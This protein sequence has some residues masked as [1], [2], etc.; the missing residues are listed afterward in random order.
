MPPKEK[1]LQINDG[2]LMAI[3][4]EPARVDTSQPAIIFLNAG[5]VHKIGPFRMN[6]QIARHLS[7]QLG[8][9]SIRFD[10][11]NIGD[12]AIHRGKIQYEY[13]VLNNISDTMNHLERI[14]G[15]T[16]FIIMGLCTGADNAHKI[17]AADERVCG[18]VFWDGYRYPTPKY[19][20]RRYWQYFL[21]LPR[22]SIAFTSTPKKISPKRKE[23]NNDPELSF[24]WV[25]PTKKNVENDFKNFLARDAKMLFIFSGDATKD[26]NYKG[27]L[28]NAFRRLKLHANIEEIYY[29]EMDH[30]YMIHSDRKKM[31][32]AVS[33][34]LKTNF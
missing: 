12:S 15:V 26:Y 29:P 14:Y 10:N 28:V 8:Y 13:H 32:A 2:S 7:K 18:A 6:I 33:E 5:L 19:L 34:W 16:K 11:A 9:L 24:D 30:T 4:T 20:S 3:A 31:Q 21:K 27:Q 1:I 25:L 17:M 22:R 23:A